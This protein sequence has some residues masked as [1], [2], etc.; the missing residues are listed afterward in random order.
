MGCIIQDAVSYKPS[1]TVIIDA[2]PNVISFHI[3]QK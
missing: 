1:S 2:P 3:V